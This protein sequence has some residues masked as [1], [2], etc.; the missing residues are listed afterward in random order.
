MNTLERYDQD[1]VSYCLIPNHFHLLV[2][3]NDSTEFVK[4]IKFG[5]A[6]V[7][8]KYNYRYELVGSLCQD[9]YKHTKIF[10]THGL[11]KVSRYIHR[12]PIKHLYPD[13][14]SVDVLRNYEWSSMQ[15]YL[16]LA[17]RVYPVDKYSVLMHFDNVDDYLQF[18]S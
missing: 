16:G 8:R 18:C 15:Y 9:R 14:N 7:T 4:F 5:M 2:S 10:T 6:Q 11:L 1:I 3:I 13:R 12:N 17:E